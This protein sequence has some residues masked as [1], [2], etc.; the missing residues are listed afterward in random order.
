MKKVLFFAVTLGAL[1]VNAQQLKL[2]IGQKIASVSR[3]DMEMDMGM[4]GQ[5]K[6]KSKTTNVLLIT[7]GDAKNFNGTNTITKMSVS[8]EGMGQSTDFDSEKKSDLDSEAGKMIGKELNKSVQ[9]SINK[10]T[11]MAAEINPEK[12]PEADSNPMAGMMGGMGEKSAAAMANGAF[13]V[14]PKG[15]KAGDKWSD[16][17]S[18]AGMKGLKNYE[19]KSIDKE[20][21]III[22]HSTSKGTISKE[23]QGMQMDI[24]MNTTSESKIIT[25]ITTGLVKNNSTSATMEGTLDMMG[26]SMPISMKLT[27]ET[28]VE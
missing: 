11:G 16:S 19:L 4:G 15:K 22:M 6:V 3:A 21:A 27:T 20:E 23:V 5:M 7:G 8:Q 18:E 12:N 1:S 2:S 24:M 17:L 28:E 9:I 10:S 26:Q 14:I 13:F 25:N